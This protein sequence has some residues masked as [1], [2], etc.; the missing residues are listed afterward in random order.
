LL[1]AWQ[2][3]DARTAKDR[4]L[5]CRRSVFTVRPETPAAPVVE[6]MRAL[7]TH[8]LFVVDDGVPVG[9]VTATD[10]LRPLEPA[11]E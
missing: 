10:I 6:D 9:M 2:V 1:L 3:N 7:R 5:P 11:L 4:T 8:C